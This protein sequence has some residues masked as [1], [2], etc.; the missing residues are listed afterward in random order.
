MG[1]SGSSLQWAATITAALVAV[2]G[3]ILPTLN[4]FAA[5]RETRRVVTVRVS[6][7]FPAG[8]AGVGPDSLYVT[9]MNPGSRGARIVSIGLRLPNKMQVFFPGAEGDSLPHDLQEG[10]SCVQ[11]AAAAE[12]ATA[13]RGTG[14]KGKVMV[15]GFCRD[16]LGTEYRSK[17]YPFDVARK[18]S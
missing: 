8:M 1:I 18:H 10:K 6:E 5:R 12:I 17:P 13:I 15:V 14:L 16:A 2:Y 3:A 4:F 9:A 11:W 7:G